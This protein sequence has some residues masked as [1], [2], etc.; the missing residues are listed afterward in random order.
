M[1]F[2]KYAGF[3]VELRDPGIALITFTRPER[4]NGLDWAVKRDLIEAMTQLQY[5]EQSRVIVFHGSGKA[6]SAG[7]NVS[8]S[9]EEGMWKDARSQPVKR[10]QHDNLSTY[11]SLRTISQN[12]TRTVR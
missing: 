8:T 3:S 7:D 2:G 6:F 9:R 4:L 12:L 5:D 10:T 11:S 1:A